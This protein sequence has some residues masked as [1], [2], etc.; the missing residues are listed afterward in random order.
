M[1]AAWCDGNPDTPHRQNL[2]SSATTYT[3]YVVQ[4][5]QDEQGDDVQSALTCGCRLAG[6]S[7]LLLI[8]Q[9]GEVA[10]SKPVVQK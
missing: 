8:Q 3:K 6:A 2:H 10:S 1:F 7:I 5:M 9:Q 4:A